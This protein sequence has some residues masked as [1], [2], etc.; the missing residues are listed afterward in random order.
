MRP[1]EVAALTIA[2]LVELAVLVSC[3]IA[4]VMMFLTWLL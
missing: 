1:L 2:V 3:L 4:A